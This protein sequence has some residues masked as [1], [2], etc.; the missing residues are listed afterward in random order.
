[1]IRLAVPSAAWVIVGTGSTFTEIKRE[2]K[3]TV[4]QLVLLES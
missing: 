2:G 3:E 1:M 4:Q